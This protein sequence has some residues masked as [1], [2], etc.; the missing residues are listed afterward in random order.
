MERKIIDWI[1][2][3]M[4]TSQDKM[5]DAVALLSTSSAGI[6]S[7]A[8]FEVVLFINSIVTPIALIITSICFITE[9]VKMSIKM[10]VLKAEYV[11]GLVFKLC[12][13]KAVID[14]SIDV[15]LLIN[16]TVT[17]WITSFHSVLETDDGQWLGRIVENLQVALSEL[18][19]WEFLGTSMTMFLPT[20]ALWIVGIIIL[21]ISWGRTFE[22]Y[23]NLA[24]API[25]FA[26]LPTEGGGNGITKRFILSYAGVCLQG[27]LM[28]VCIKIY[29]YFMVQIMDM[30]A[31]DPNPHDIVGGVLLASLILLI[32]IT[33]CGQ[34]GKQIMNA[35]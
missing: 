24:I 35:M 13:S 14:I 12:L 7:S 19:F 2:G 27:L 4:A 21:V 32:S 3:I 29:Q 23:V 17:E 9:F 20:V 10:D 25:P 33:K 11:L 15:L 1:L 5:D 22:I 8:V 18:S 6:E 26:F 34:W 31:V 28:L 30:G 16:Q